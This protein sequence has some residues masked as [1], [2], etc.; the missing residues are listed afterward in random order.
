MSLSPL[1]QL[2]A[3]G[4]VLATISQSLYVADALRKDIDGLFEEDVMNFRDRSY[5]KTYDGPREAVS[6]TSLQSPLAI[7]LLSSHS[8]AFSPFSRFLETKNPRCGD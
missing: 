3:F 5:I 1:K 6:L 8:R 4:I 2:V 7:E